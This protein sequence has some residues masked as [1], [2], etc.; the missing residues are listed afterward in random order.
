MPR[1]HWK[2]IHPVCV[3]LVSSVEIG[4]GPENVFADLSNRKQQPH[5]KAIHTHVVAD[6]SEIPDTFLDQCTNQMFGNAA[7]PEPADHDSGTVK[8]AANRLLCTSND[9]VHKIKRENQTAE[10][11]ASQAAHPRQPRGCGHQQNSEGPHR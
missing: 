11:S 4:Y 9:L 8:N 5:P 2:F 6:R 1:S 3:E 7:Q 10:I